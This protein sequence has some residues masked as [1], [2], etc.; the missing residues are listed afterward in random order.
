MTEIQATSVAGAFGGNVYQSGGGIWLVLLQRADG[1]LVVISDEAIC[2]YD[3]EEAFERGDAKTT[4][5]L[6]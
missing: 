2:L 1:E 4:I 5:V 6:H 3:D